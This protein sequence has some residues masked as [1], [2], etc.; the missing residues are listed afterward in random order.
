YEGVQLLRND[1]QS[2]NWLQVR[3][4]SR[5]GGT[6]ATKGLGDGSTV[7]ARVSEVL[8]RRS[9]TGASYLSQ[10][11]RVLHFGLGDAGALEDVEVRWLAGEPESFGSLEANAIWELTEGSGVARRVSAPSR[12]SDREQVLEFWNLQRAGM[13]AVKIEGDLPKAIGLFRQALT[14]D[15]QHEDSRYYLANCLAAEGDLDGALAELDTMRRLSP[16]SHRAHKQWGVLRAMTAESDADLEAAERALARALYINQEATGSLLVLGEIALMRGDRALADERLAQATR[17]NPKAVGGFF[18]RGY[19]AWKD[20]ESADAGRH[21]EAALAARGPEWKP[22][23]TVAE[24]DVASRMHRE[25][26]PLSLYWE[27][28]D[29]TPDPQTAFADL[30]SYLVSR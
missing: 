22:E 20:G 25:V 17:T 4:R 16:G 7:T 3:L 28:W 30:D 27:S 6:D 23:G 14:L 13:D 24:G 26:T 29:G 1:M 8:L 5:V 19:I 15:P 9:M 12:L 11:S 18:L 2:G 10:G 21:R